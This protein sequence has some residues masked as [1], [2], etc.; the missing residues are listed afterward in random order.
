MYYHIL[1]IAVLYTTLED[2]KIPYR[3]L[4][5]GTPIQ[6]NLKELFSLLHFVQPKIFNDMNQFLT[7]FPEKDFKMK[8][9]D[10]QLVGDLQTVLKPFMLRRTKDVLKDLP[11]KRE[12]LL[13]CSMVELQKKYYLGVLKKDVTFLKNSRSL[14]NI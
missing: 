3:V 4:L 10:E 6:N 5:T 11:K 8:K 1:T 13:Y 12:F 2:Y 7:I 14:M 9:A